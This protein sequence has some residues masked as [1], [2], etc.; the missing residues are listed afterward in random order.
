[1]NE[2]EWITTEEACKIS[3]YNPVYLRILL[4][5]DKIKARKFGPVWQVNRNSLVRFLENINKQGKK[6]GPKKHPKT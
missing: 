3:G 2:S 1:M 5:N 4:R 6:R